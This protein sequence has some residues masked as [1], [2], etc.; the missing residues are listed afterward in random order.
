MAIEVTNLRP[1]NARVGRSYPAGVVPPTP[2]VARDVAM[3]GN[4]ITPAR[5]TELLRER[6]AGYRSRWVDFA[7]E[8]LRN[9]PHMLA[10]KLLA[11]ETVSETEFRITP[12]DESAPAAKAAD[13]CARLWK[14]WSRR[15]L[16]A[17]IEEIVGVEYYG[18]GAHEVRWL[19]DGREVLPAALERLLERRCSYACEWTDPR[20]WALRL[21]DEDAMD[22]PVYGVP[23]EDF[24]ADKVLIHEPRVLGG[25]RTLEGLFSG[26]VWYSVF[27]IWAWRDLIALDEMLGR[28]PAIAY[29]AAGG[30]RMGREGEFNGARNATDKEIGAGQAAVFNLSG[31]LRAVLP[32]TIRVELMKIQLPTGEPL[33]LLTEDRANKL[34]SKAWHGI[35]TVSDLKPGA[36]AAQQVQERTGNTRWRARCFRVA[37]TFERL[38]GWYVA[39]NPQVFGVD[40]PPPCVEPDIAPEV[41]RLTVAKGINESR[42][43]GIKV[44][45]KWAHKATQIPEPA[46]GEDVL[47]ADIAPPPGARP[48]GAAD[49]PDDEQNDDAE[50][51]DART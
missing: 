7:D 49:P 16:R 21:L 37:A 42:R 51:E 9:N 47:D 22:R 41:D 45:R 48:P 32:D 17:W 38:F 27:T 40:C 20:P 13:A 43:A 18:A 29:Y 14:A 24:G 35:D 1:A 50:P 19:R 39:A 11:E 3:V 23:L 10:Q 34:I 26:C 5:L 8:Q 30:A 2:Y 31:S 33:Q 12:G 44:P 6:N 25:V 36:R 15:G 46:P 4:S 28:P